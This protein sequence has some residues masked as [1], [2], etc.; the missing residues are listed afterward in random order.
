MVEH[1]VYYSDKY[2]ILV[3]ILNRQKFSRQKTM[4]NFQKI[5]CRYKVRLYSYVFK[6]TSSWRHIY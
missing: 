5:L 6:N 3:I 4:S 1:L 2:I